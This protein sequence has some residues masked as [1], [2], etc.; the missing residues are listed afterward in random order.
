MAGVLPVAT[1]SA[2]F[3]P[4]AGE[5]LK[6]QV[7]HPQLTMKFWTSSISEMIGL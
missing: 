3:Q 5:A 6:P 7:P 1:I 4:L 2:V